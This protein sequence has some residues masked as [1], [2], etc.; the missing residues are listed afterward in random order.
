MNEIAIVIS[1]IEKCDKC[2][3][4]MSDI[5]FTKKKYH[6]TLIKLNCSSETDYSNKTYHNAC[7]TPQI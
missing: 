6:I 4:C 5:I 1:N 2:F 7:N 3:N